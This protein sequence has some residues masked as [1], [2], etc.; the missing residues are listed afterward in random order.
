MKIFQN[1]ILFFF[2]LILSLNSLAQQYF[3]IIPHNLVVA[4]D[5][6][7]E[8]DYGCEN[9]NPT[10]EESEIAN[11]SE[12]EDEELGSFFPDLDDDDKTTIYELLD[13]LTTNSLF[14]IYYPVYIC[15]FTYTRLI[16]PPDHC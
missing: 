16:M 11:D 6:G 2:L 15:N 8:D 10:S 12:E 13:H 4:V 9:I 14:L 1:I 3:Y 5:S 7:T